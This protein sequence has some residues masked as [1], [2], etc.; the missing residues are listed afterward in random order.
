MDIGELIKQYGYT[1]AEFSRKFKI[2][3]RTVQ[4]WCSEGSCHRNC[5]DYIKDLVDYRLKN[6]S[7]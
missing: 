7:K 3:Y 2:P 1:K 6:E 5:P 4:N